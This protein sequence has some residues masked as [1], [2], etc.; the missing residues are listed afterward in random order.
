MSRDGSDDN[1][2]ARSLVGLNL[3]RGTKGGGPSPAPDDIGSYLPMASLLPRN[4]GLFGSGWARFMADRL[5]PGVNQS[6]QDPAPG[7][8]PVAALQK[9]RSGQVGDNPGAYA[10]GRPQSDQLTRPDRPLQPSSNALRSP[11]DMAQGALR[12]FQAAPKIARPNLAESFI[13]VV[14]PA[15]EAAG[16]LQDGN[17]AGAAFN[18]AMAVADALPVGVAIK[19]FK[20]AEKG[21]GVLKKGSV[22]AGA[23]AS[24]LRRWGIAKK[25]EEIHHAI[26][27]NGASRS[28]QDW[29]NH[30]AFLKVLPKEQHRR[31]TGSWNGKPMYDPIRRIWYGTTDWMKAVPTGVAGYAA[32]AWEN[33]TDP[34][35]ASASGS[36][37]KPQR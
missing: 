18:G 24:Q 26:P 17:Y 13:P 7:P 22:T 32:D 37:K 36:P 16:D 28:A 34:F 25:G 15:W 6:R 9:V 5:A 8:R 35:S 31:L 14:G 19:G 27:L 10:N 1:F 20:A 21:V 29:R 33:L 2:G 30:Y 12:D 4:R 3:L 23:A 11:L